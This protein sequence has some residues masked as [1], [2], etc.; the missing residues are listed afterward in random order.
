MIAQHSLA[1][2]EGGGQRYLDGFPSPEDM[3]VTPDGR[4][5]LLSP[6]SSLDGSEKRSLYL[7]DIETQ[8]VEPLVY[9]HNLGSEAW[10][11]P[12]CQVSPGERFGTHGIDVSTRSDGSIQLSAVNHN[13]E[14]VEFF[15]ILEEK[16]KVFISWR[17]CVEFPPG[18]VLN[19]VVNTPADGILVTN[20]F[21]KHA[22]DVVAIMAS[23]SPAGSIFE[24]T[25]EKG[26]AELF[27]GKLFVPNSIWLDS[28]GGGK[29]YVSESGAESFSIFDMQSLERVLKFP[30]HGV[31]NLTFSARNE[32]I[33]TTLKSDLPEECVRN[34][35]SMEFSCAVPFQ[36][37]SLDLKDQVVRSVLEHSGTPLGAPSVALLVDGVYYIGSF[38]GEGML[39]IDK[40]LSQ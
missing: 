3:A 15:E 10:G 13:R 21:D 1:S 31:D 12:A 25:A 30:V 6:F 27:A 23:G 8:T 20:M 33:F 37:K 28:S 17:G 16:G 34:A 36:V 5:I 18:S 24:W 40:Q 35:G 26:I 9:R 7:F 29:L 19:D 38:V 32:L 14:S 39:V 2:G 4:Y 11:D 22:G